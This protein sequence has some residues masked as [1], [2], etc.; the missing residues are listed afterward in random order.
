MMYTAANLRPHL[1]P[2]PSQTY[3]FLALTYFNIVLPAFPPAAPAAFWHRARLAKAQMARTTASPYLV[4]RALQM[5]QT[6]GARAR[7]DAPPAPPLDPAAFAR[8]APSAALLGLSLIGNLDRTYVRA[9]YPP[10]AAL[11][12]RSV[13]TA[14]RLRAGG[15]LL[16][17]HTF[18]EQ[19]WVHLC[20]DAMGFEEGQVERFWGELKGAVEEYLC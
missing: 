7:G 17:A 1:S 15:M 3:W 5:A 14:S 12:L 11:E 2:I 18:G 9:A 16:L 8:P 20:W 10:S 13:T 6:R 4:A 19:L